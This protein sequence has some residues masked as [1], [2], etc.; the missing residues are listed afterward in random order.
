MI[1][2]NIDNI[3]LI[4]YTIYFMEM[5]KEKIVI[6]GAGFGGLY[7]LKSI[8]QHLKNWR[9]FDILIIDRNNYFVFTPLLHEVA[10]GGIDPGDIVFPIRDLAKEGTEHLEAEV[11]SVDML[12]KSVITSHGEIS[13][14]YLVMALG[15]GTNFFGVSGAAENTFTLKNIK[16]ATRLKNHL[17]HIFDEANKEQNLERQKDIL[18]IV[19]IGG[20]ATGV[21]F[22]AEIQEFLKEINKEYSNIPEAAVEFYL[23]EAGDRLLP[24]FHPKFSKK[25]LKILETKGF[26]IMFKDPCVQVTPQ[27][28]V[29][30]SKNSVKSQ[31]VIWTSGVLPSQIVITPEIERQKGRIAVQET[32]NVKDFPEVFILGDQAAFLDKRFGLLPT[33]A[34]VAAEQGNFIGENINRL[35]SNRPLKKFKYFHK[36]DLVSLGKWK[37]FA[38]IGGS[39]IRFGGPLAWLIWRF[40]YLTQMPGGFKK[41]RLFFDWLL[42]LVGKR[43][44]SEI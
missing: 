30:A 39:F 29:C 4:E 40:N 38:Q 9:D 21:E 18:R 11:L 31:T 1:L 36:G 15:A 32:L 26:K 33:S 22:A 42:Y 20:G 10:T 8:Y 43:D 16:D 23:I 3:L 17:I 37:A 5:A 12:K 24:I 27:G 19:I 35:I 13:Y 34:Q 7:A 41:V 44:I 6:L 14:D 2:F 25:A 28:I